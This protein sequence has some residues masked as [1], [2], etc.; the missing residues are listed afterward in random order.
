MRAKKSFIDWGIMR[1]SDIRNKSN[2]RF[3]AHCNI[4]PITPNSAD[5]CQSYID[6]LCQDIPAVFD[7]TTM[8]PQI[9]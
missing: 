3:N 5:S 7:N 1:N 4:A 8:L 6:L 9:Q 2:T